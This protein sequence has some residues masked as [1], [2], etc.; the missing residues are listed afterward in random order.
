M[1]HP[2]GKIRTM[3][4]T[5]ELMQRPDII[6]SQEE[7]YSWDNTKNGQCSNC[8]KC[9]SNMLPLTRTDIRRI[10]AYIEKNHIRPHWHMST[11]TSTGEDIT[12]PFRNDAEKRCEIYAVRPAI[13][14]IYRCDN[15]KQGI[16][17]HLDEVSLLKDL[18]GHIDV[19][20]A[21]FGDT[22]G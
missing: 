19:R 9:C 16:D 11:T 5:F 14:K 22:K 20:E 10:R 15:W 3:A 18:A 21:F 13:C 7:L 12:C 17:R 2:K 1:S 6:P 8:G 4:D